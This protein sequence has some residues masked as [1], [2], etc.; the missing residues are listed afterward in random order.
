MPEILPITINKNKLSFK[1][2]DKMSGIKS[3]E[4]RINN[5][6][7]LFEYDNKNKMIISKK[8]YS[9]KPFKGKFVLIVSDNAENK[10]TYKLNI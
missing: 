6:W 9:N 2:D 1:I 5:E 3:Y 4:A 10:V 7:I 8:K